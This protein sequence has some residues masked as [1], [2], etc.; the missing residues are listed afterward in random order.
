[1]WGDSNAAAFYPGLKSLQ[2]KH[3]FSIAQ[4]TTSSCP[5]LLG[6]NNTHRKFCN[7]INIA[8]LK[9]VRELNPETVILHANWTHSLTPSLAQSYDLTFL[10]NT[11]EELRKAKVKKI[12][13]LG[14]VPRWTENLHRIIF[15]NW[16]YSFHRMPSARLEKQLDP[17][18]PLIDQKMREIA[19]RLD[20]VYISAWDV[21]CDKAGCLTRTPEE[22]YDIS[23]FDVEHLSPSASRYLAHHIENDLLGK[24]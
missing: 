17:N 12:V 1:M 19:Q 23:T 11:V 2:E 3:P 20:V 6:L 10:A 4:F 13:I 5:P 24:K 7:E 22:G 15:H 21:M 9:R 16:K 14:P 8:N 18:V